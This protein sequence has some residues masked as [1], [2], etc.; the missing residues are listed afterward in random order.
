MFMHTVA[1]DSPGVWVTQ[2]ASTDVTL[3]VVQ[4]PCRGLADAETFV[5]RQMVTSAE[6]G[7][8][9]GGGGGGS[10]TSDMVAVSISFS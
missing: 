7:K 8:V 3:L 1:A 2:Q 10:A 6:A 4:H 9:V 5:S